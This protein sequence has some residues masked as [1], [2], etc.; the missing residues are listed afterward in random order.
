MAKRPV[1]RPPAKA[2]VPN[3]SKVELVPESA[4]PPVASGPRASPF[5]KAQLERWVRDRCGPG[6]VWDDETQS[7][8]RIGKAPNCIMRLAR[9]R[10]HEEILR[11][12]SLQFLDP[13][14]YWKEIEQLESAG[15]EP[16][17]LKTTLAILSKSLANLVEFIASQ[18]GKRAHLDDVTRQIDRITKP[19]SMCARRNTVRTRFERARK[20]MEAEKTPLVIGIDNLVLFLRPRS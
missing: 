11:L 8:V 2:S 19:G 6:G 4:M 9:E 3:A 10:N 1:E 15:E 20:L 17:P 12:T 16:D 7:I 14:A 5:E 13:D 18:P